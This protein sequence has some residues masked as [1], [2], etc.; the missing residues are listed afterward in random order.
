MADANH[1]LKFPTIVPD[2]LDNVPRAPISVPRMSVLEPVVI[3]PPLSASVPLARVSVRLFTETA[4][5]VVLALEPPTTRFDSDPPVRVP[6]VVDIAPL[7]V[8]VLKS[9]KESVPLIS[10]SVP[11]T[12]ILVPRVVLPPFI[13]M[14]LKI[15]VPLEGRVLVA[16]S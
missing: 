3:S 8:K 5:R 2:V 13:V 14:L 15:V 12:V 16:V 9:P 1:R 11:L 10:V 6:L 4:G 7:I